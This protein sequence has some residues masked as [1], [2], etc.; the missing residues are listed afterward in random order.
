MNM[1]DEL[2]TE[3]QAPKRRGRPA[4]STTKPAARAA[5][6]KKK[7]DYAPQLMPYVSQP[8]NGLI[9]AGMMSGNDI[10]VADGYA[11]AM[12][13]PNVLKALSDV[14]NDIPALG[15]VL[16]RMAKASPY[17][18]IIEAVTPLLAQLAVN[19]VEKAAPFAAR[20]GAHNPKALAAAAKQE[21][22]QQTEAFMA[23]E[24]PLETE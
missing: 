2:V 13:G 1:A 7:K 17:V 15:N 11:I 8:A 18:A 22:A 21:I 16:D 20:L 3:P 23:Y 19:H 5:T 9:A 14:A 12:H 4:G 10:L 6:P 24:E